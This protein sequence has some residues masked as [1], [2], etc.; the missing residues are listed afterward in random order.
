VDSRIDYKYIWRKMEA[1]AQKR[2]EDGDEWGPWPML[3]Q[4]GATAS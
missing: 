2:A 4:L 1:A 3:H